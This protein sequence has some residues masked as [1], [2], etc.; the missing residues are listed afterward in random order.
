MFDRRL[1]HHF[2]WGLMG[3]TLLLG[4][5]GLATLYSAVTADPPPAPQKILFFKQII[6]FC[7]GMAVMIVAFSFNYRLLD[8]WAYPIYFA[9]ILMLLGVMLFGKLA[10]GSRRWLIIGPVHLQPSELIKIA[11][12]V[13][14]A[15]YYSK[16]MNS[17]GFSLRELIRPVVVVAVPSV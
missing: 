2:D 3:V 4:G 17:S 8:R 16:N 15:K 13:V 10:G 9:C 12:V 7:I 5:I 11:V 14:L 1:V 6:W